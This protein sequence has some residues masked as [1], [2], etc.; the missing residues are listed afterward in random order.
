MIISDNFDT[1]PGY[2][3]MK[4]KNLTKP[5][6]FNS[7]HSG[8]YYPQSFLEISRLNDITIRQ[9][10]DL[11]VDDLFNDMTEYGALL[12]KAN[13]PRAYIDVNREAYELDPKMFKG[14]L[15]PYV[16]SHSIRVTGG[17][18]TIARQVSEKQEIYKS[19]LEVEEGLNRI[20][21][22]YKPYHAILR[23]LLA[24]IHSLFGYC[25]LIDCHSM[26]SGMDRQN[27]KRPDFV[28]GDR[29][30]T[31][32]SEELTE[33]ITNSLRSR[34]YK[35]TLNKP[36]AGGF[37]TEHYGKPE[38]GFHSLQIEINRGLYANE[39]NLLKNSQFDLIK[40]DI[41]LIFEHIFANF[42]HRFKPTLS[43]AAE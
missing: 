23:K 29:Y 33:I 25:V 7:P 34:G 10:E 15:P 31:S 22:L 32:C 2:K 8:Q 6:L 39:K 14:T 26:P 12:L 13:F 38:N 18:G 28:I 40:S 16:N 37:I 35:V 24:E 30:G 17:L 11:F 4:G 43:H 36:Y 9:S 5:F 27:T 20:E 3:V 41:N 42:K 21:K 19:R 1:V